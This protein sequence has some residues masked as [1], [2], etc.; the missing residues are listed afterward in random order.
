MSLRMEM[1]LFHFKWHC[2]PTMYT[3]SSH[4]FSCLLTHIFYYLRKL[5]EFKKSKVIPQI[6]IKTKPLKICRDIEDWSF[7]N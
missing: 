1:L 7:Q 2:I 5:A 6:N 3:L 4:N